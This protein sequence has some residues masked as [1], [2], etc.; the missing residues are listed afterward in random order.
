MNRK[1]RTKNVDR[2]VVI[3]AGGS[4]LV[5]ALTAAEGGADVTVIEKRP[6]P[7]GTS[8]F[9]SGPFAVESRLQ[10]QKYHSLTKDEAFKVFMDH[11]HWRA[12]PRLARAFIDESARTI[13]WLQ[14]QGVEFTEPS[15]FW[16]GG[17]YTQH[18]IKG[19]GAAMIKTLLAKT[20]EKGVEVLLRTSGKSIIKEEG[21]IVGIL[22]EDASGKTIR[23]NGGAVIIATGGYANNAEMIKRYTG[24][25]LGHDLFMPLELQ[26]TGDGIR[27]AWAAGAGEEGMGVLQLQYTV[28]GP[29][30]S[31]TSPSGIS[32]EHLARKYVDVISRQPY[33]WINEQGMRF[34]DES[35]VANWPFM[36]NTIARQKNRTVFVIFDGHTK[37]YMEEKGIVHGAGSAALP[38][39]R[40]VDLDS[41][42]TK[43]LDEGSKNI[44]AAD[45][46]QQLADN[47][48]INADIFL[49]N[50]NEYNRFCEKGHDDLFAKSPRYLQPVKEP[51][52]Y[53]FRVVLRFWGTLGGIKINEKTEALDNNNVVVPGLYAVGNDAGGLWGGTEDLL[54]P[55]EA[56]GFALNSSRIAGRNALDYITIKEGLKDDT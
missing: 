34:C 27:M 23:I 54:L 13:Q 43:Y 32:E 14:E 29:G 39:S 41:Q 47:I 16:T 49:E 35:I 28:P 33:L 55:G 4:G 15:A 5:A 22:A 36:S 40:I 45:S 25:E 11:R 53:A 50:V 19:R 56:L 42:I 20:R 52:F 21:K 1:T 10:Q 8:N 18:L 12:D 6:A 3:G 51:R 30:I 44:F 37:K 31:V 38:T 26:L 7:G 48:G 46:L 9:P 24:F 17:H 2:V